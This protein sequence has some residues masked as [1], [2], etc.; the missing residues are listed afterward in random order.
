MEL[1]FETQIALQRLL[2]PGLM[3]LVGGFLLSRCDAGAAEAPEQ[4]LK[5]IA[6]PSLAGAI[7]IGCGIAASDLWQR[8]LIARPMAWRE[9]EAREPWMWMVWAVPALVILL[10]AARAV[11]RTG[12][13][14][15]SWC[16]PIAVTCGAGFMMI[17]LPQ[18]PGYEDKLREAMHWV[19]LGTIAIVWN[20]MALNGIAKHPGG[21]WAPLVLLAQVGA[22]AGMVVQS[23]A[24]LGELVLA[25][26]GTTAGLT[27]VSLL[28]PTS[29]STE[30]GWRLAPAVLALVIAAVAALSVST[31]YVST[32]PAPWILFSVLL[33]PTIVGIAD[34]FLRAR[35]MVWRLVIGAAIAGSIVGAVVYTALS[36]TPDF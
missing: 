32:P 33:L 23:Y 19:G 24:S 20:A 21:R 9:W 6:L 17:V 4:P 27:F 36:H 2:V 13:R 16:L 35:P 29:H 8:G 34:T 14:W 26:L 12:S 3:G 25:L 30:F 28:I 11:A 7:L 22:I 31:F 18:G 10:A 5:G 1:S 15:A